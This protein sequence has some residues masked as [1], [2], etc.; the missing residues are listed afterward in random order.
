MRMRRSGCIR[1]SRGTRGAIDY[2]L[3][4]FAHHAPQD[5]Y[6][7]VKEHPLD[8]GVKNW[9]KLV[10]RIARKYGIQ[11]R[12][13]YLECGDIAVLVRDARG[14]VTI[15]STTGTLAL[16]SNVPTITLGQAIYDISGI[17]YQ[18]SLNDFWRN[19]T[20]PDEKIFNA[21]RRVLIDRCMIEGGFFSEEGLAKLVNGTLERIRS[22]VRANDG[23]SFVTS[24]LERLNVIKR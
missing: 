8:N 20:P 1:S 9:R 4:S 10:M 15:N 18:G 23:S 24:S 17:T 2:V 22:S 3:Q 19:P 6:L 13:R 14:V 21:F 7:L 16:A 12:V 11:D 5:L